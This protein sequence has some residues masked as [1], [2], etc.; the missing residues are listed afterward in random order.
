MASTQTIERALRER[1]GSEE[2]I[3]TLAEILFFLKSHQNSHYAAVEQ[4]NQQTAHGAQQNTTP[5]QGQSRA[6][7]RTRK[8]RAAQ[9][10]RNNNAATSAAT[11]PQQQPQPQDTQG[12][13]NQGNLPEIQTPEPKRQPSYAEIAQKASEQTPQQPRKPKK[14]RT[15]PESVKLAPKALKPLKIVLREPIKDLPNELILKIKDRAVNGDR[16]ASLIKAFRILTPTSLL[17]YATTEAAREELSQNT[18]WLDA[19]HASFYTRYYSIVTYRIRRDI[20]IQDISRRIREQNPI[21]EESLASADWLGKE[22]GPYGTLKV[23]ITD[24]IVA[25]RAILRG[26]TLDYEFKKVSQYIPR[27]RKP[28]EQ[29]EKLFYKEKT[30]KLPP[31]VVFSAAGESDTS[32]TQDEEW[33]LVEGTQKRRQIAPKGRGRPKT[34]E[35]IDKSHGNIDKFILTTQ[36]SPSVIPETQDL[37]TDTQES[38]QSMNVD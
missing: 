31:K 25:N 7:T 16:L 32:R 11:Q 3:V 26:I 1:F 23:N 13:Q 37:T 8:E 5:S 2:T 24:P 15:L 27:R 29:R 6:S 33:V 35:R 22:K 28:I 34:F 19:I 20:P 17:V 30:P 14:A 12:P 9:E 36:I 10:T 21:L 4:K 18:S 38:V